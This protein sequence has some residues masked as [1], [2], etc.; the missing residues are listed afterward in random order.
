MRVVKDSKEKTKKEANI[1][2]TSEQKAKQDNIED[3]NV[4]NVKRKKFILIIAI[5]ILIFIFIGII[6]LF[7]YPQ[8]KLNGPQSVKLNLN[9]EYKE[10]GFVAKKAFKNI[11]EQVKIDGN[12]DTSKPGK[13]TI[14]YSVKDGIFANKVIRVVE[15]VD[16]IKPEIKLKGAAEVNICPNSK[17][18]EIGFSAV[19]NYDGD[20]TERVVVLENENLIT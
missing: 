11:N 13:Y 18:E 3:N 16:N 5:V 19:D 4:S 12:I 14:A 2:V 9:E 1:K 20:I 17:Y 6:S 7:N 10:Y 15:V 8:L